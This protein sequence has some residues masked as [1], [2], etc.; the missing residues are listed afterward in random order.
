MANT[1]LCPHCGYGTVK[2]ID[3]ELVCNYCQTTIEQDDL[4]V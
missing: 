4:D 2:Q 1:Y 3:D